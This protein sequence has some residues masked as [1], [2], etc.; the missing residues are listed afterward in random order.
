MFGY[1]DVIQIY[2]QG[3]DLNESEIHLS[4]G[5]GMCSRCRADRCEVVWASICDGR[6]YGEIAVD[7]IRKGLQEQTIWKY[8][9][10]DGNDMR[11]LEYG[12][13]HLRQRVVAIG[14]QPKS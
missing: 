14:P 11:A 3:N 1:L 8:T 7:Q 5:Y 9:H 6:Y 4:M 2:T 13:D 10:L 12:H